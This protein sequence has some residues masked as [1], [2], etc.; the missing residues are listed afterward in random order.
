[1]NVNKQMPKDHAA[2]NRI[3]H[4][5]SDIYATSYT[6]GWLF[7][8]IGK[9]LERLQRYEEEL[10]MQMFPQSAT[11]ALGYWEQK[12]HI[13]SNTNQPF[14]VRRER[15]IG[16]SSNRAPVTPAK[17]EHVLSMHSGCHCIIYENAEP[18]TFHVVLYPTDENTLNLVLLKKTIEQMK[19]AHLSYQMIIEK[20]HNMK[21]NAGF[22][23]HIGTAMTIRQVM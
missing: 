2:V 4:Y 18:Y 14:N 23:M 16:K 11:W 3:M 22:G 12:F 15:I 9:E 1:M 17:M 6:G 19:P 10:E 20:P 8:A 5:V 13:D 21:I 7:D